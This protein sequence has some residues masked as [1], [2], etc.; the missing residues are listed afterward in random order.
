[1][2]TGALMADP[3][4]LKLRARALALKQSMD[5]VRSDRTPDFAKWT[6]TNSFIRNYNSLAK[7]FIRLKRGDRVSVYDTEKLKSA[8]DMVWPALKAHFDQIYTDT[9]T[10]LELTNVTETSMDHG[11]IYNLLV[12]GSKDEWNGDAFQIE[13]S[14]CAREYTS[15]LLNE[16]FGDF[17][18]K[19]IDELKKAPCIFAYEFG[20][21][22]DPK[23]G[24]IKD[25]TVRQ[26]Q[27]RVDYEIKEVVPFLSYEQLARDSFEF[28][29]AK[30]ELYRTHW[31]VKEVNLAK[32]LN[33]MGIEIPNE[34]RDVTSPVDISNHIFEVALSFPGEVRELVEKIVPELERRLGP[35]SYFYDNNYSS[36]LAR[37]NLDLLLQ[38][39]YRN[40]KIDVV[41][42]SAD[43]QRKD[44][45]G[46]EFKAVRE[47]MSNR[48]NSRVMFIRT[49][50]GEVEGVF[51]TDGYIDARKFEA[52]RIAE[53]ICERVALGREASLKKAEDSPR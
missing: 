33:R 16:K 51:K 49:D 30:M 39:V 11:P 43:Y 20:H 15:K 47:I 53:F 22:M 37:P 13:M 48:D 12:S 40:A 14:R 23:F 28:D 50:D 41:F 52:S 44:W 35:N 17:S 42:L 21:E 10:L 46:I 2:A 32:E 3:E 29:I 36:Q 8:A 19:A 34:L 6:G 45:C 38:N 5:A 24:Y 25:V 31:A 1:V 27:V 7:E 4:L 18:Q 26:G 9:V